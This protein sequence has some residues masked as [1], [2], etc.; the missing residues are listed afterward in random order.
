MRLTLP[1]ENVATGLVRFLSKIGDVCVS[2]EGIVYPC[3][4]GVLLTDDAG[5][6]EMNHIHRGKNCPT[7]VLSF[8]SVSYPSGTAKN[9]QKRLRKEWD[10]DAGCVHLGDIAVSS[11][12]AQAQAERYGHSYLREM[13][14]LFAHGVL[15]LMGYDHQMESDGAAMRAMEEEIMNHAGIVRELSA[16][17]QEMV[18][19]AWEA[20]QAAYVPYSKYYV[21]ACVKDSE[22]RLFKGCNVENASFGLTICAERNAITTAVTEGMRKLHAIAIVSENRNAENKTSA[23]FDLPSPCGACRQ[24]MREFGKDVKIILACPEGAAITSLSALL[25][26]SFGPESLA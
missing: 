5:I 20:L 24:F 14:F 22:G 23:S 2:M 6:T 1:D 18:D 12:R 11:E 4:V 10:A 17:D 8:P 19:L 21:G 26:D 3:Q 9:H 16:E 7:D 13:G 15:H 25:P